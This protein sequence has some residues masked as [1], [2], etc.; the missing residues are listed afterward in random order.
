MQ[1]ERRGEGKREKRGTKTS[2]TWDFFSGG[3]ENN[4]KGGSHPS[5]K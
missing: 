4:K 2:V 1:A 5:V 3:R